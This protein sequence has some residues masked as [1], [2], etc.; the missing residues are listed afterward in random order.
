MTYEEFKD[1]VSFGEDHH[2]VYIDDQGYYCRVALTNLQ[3]IPRELIPPHLD[4]KAYQDFLNY[5]KELMARELW[6]MLQKEVRG[7]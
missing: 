2:R 4:E 5:Q 6:D 1:K 3:C 7:E